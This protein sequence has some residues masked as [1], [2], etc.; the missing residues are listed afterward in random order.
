MNR[1][2]PGRLHHPY[3]P[4]GIRCWLIRGE[5]LDFASPVSGLGSKMGLDA[6]EANGRASRCGG[7]LCA[8][9][10]L[11][12]GIDERQYWTGGRTRWQNADNW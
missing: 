1:R 7:R 9:C 11:A 4:C 6:P 12:S 5:L 8:V 10:S 2:R 3:G